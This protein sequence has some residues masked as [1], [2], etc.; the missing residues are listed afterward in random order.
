[1]TPAERFLCLASD[2]HAHTHTRVGVCFH[3][4][5]HDIAGVSSSSLYQ[6]KSALLTLG[7]RP[8]VRG[9]SSQARETLRRHFSELQATATQLL[10]ERLAALLAEVDAVEAASVKPLDDCQSII[11]HGVGQ[12]DELLREG[13]RLPFLLKSSSTPASGL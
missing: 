4:H 13:G 8:Q 9:S 6:V 5:S 7:P 1:M 10:T 2:T 12:A 11:E 3:S